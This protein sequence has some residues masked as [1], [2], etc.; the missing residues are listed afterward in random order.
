MP[1]NVLSLLLATLI[2]SWWI[3]FL[4]SNQWNFW[5][6]KKYTRWVGICNTIFPTLQV[7]S[8]QILKQKECVTPYWRKWHSP[9][10]ILGTE[11]LWVGL[12]NTHLLYMS[13]MCH[14][15]SRIDRSDKEHVSVFLSARITSYF[16]PEPEY[17]IT[18]FSPITVTNDLYHW[19]ALR[20]QGILC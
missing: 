12:I 19:Q 16:S 11:Y 18:V 14:C 20:L 1:R 15:K 3:I 5:K 13:S 2:H 10:Y 9:Q 8:G 7:M 17:L 4:H 6:E